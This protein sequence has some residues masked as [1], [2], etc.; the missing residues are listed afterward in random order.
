MI[1]SITELYF[2]FMDSINNLTR[3]YEKLCFYKL[4]WFGDVEIGNIYKEKIKNKEIERGGKQK[5]EW[6]I[7]RCNF[8]W[9]SFWSI[10]DSD[11]LYPS[12]HGL[13]VACQLQIFTINKRSADYNSQ[14]RN[15]I[16]D[17]IMHL[18]HKVKFW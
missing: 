13:H 2:N 18:T 7:K 17:K 3:T 12:P 10:L 4:I 14:L 5:V 9:G 15:I 1:G 11:L 16:Y 6:V 8:L